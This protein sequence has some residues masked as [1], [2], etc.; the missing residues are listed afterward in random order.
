M[1]VLSVLIR[2]LGAS[3]CLLL[4]HPAARRPRNHHFRVTSVNPTS[5]TPL[6]AKRLLTRYI[7]QPRR[8]GTR[9]DQK[10]HRRCFVS[11]VVLRFSSC[12]DGVDRFIPV[13]CHT[14]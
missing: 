2:V 10:A 5:K 7:T 12:G 11:G 3:R 6:V 4:V 8:G 1:V 9:P 13:C 14:L